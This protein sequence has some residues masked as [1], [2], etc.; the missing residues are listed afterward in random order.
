MNN[1][2]YVSDQTGNNR[3]GQVADDDVERC[4]EAWGYGTVPRVIASVGRSNLC[5]KNGIAAVAVATS[6]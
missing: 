1:L 2:T 4:G 6:Q 3:S 5:L